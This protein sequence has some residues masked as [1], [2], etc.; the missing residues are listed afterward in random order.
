MFRVDCER[1]K[2]DKAGGFL[3]I[4]YPLTFKKFLNW[5]GEGGKGGGASINHLPTY[6]VFF[7]ISHDGEFIFLFFKLER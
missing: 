2:G 3:L 1:V 6:L 7:L 5:R 4:T